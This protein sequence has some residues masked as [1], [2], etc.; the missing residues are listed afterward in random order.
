MSSSL[1]V[2]ALAKKR[3]RAASGAPNASAAVAAKVK[4]DVNL[5]D[6]FGGLSAKKAAVAEAAAKA[7]A[8]RAAV[9]AAE[10]RASRAVEALE[11]AGR[12]ANSGT[13]PESPV[14]L[15]F[16]QELGVRV[17]AASALRIGAGEGNT[18]DCPFDCECCF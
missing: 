4:D 14:P 13:R 16:D 6:I 5:D 1:N 8:S 9:A 15:R 2:N 11:A 18:K 7:A 3:K 12:A 10:I 17:F